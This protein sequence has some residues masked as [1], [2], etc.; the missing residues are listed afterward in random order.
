MTAGEGGRRIDAN[1]VAALS[2]LHTAER[3]ELT[4]LDIQLITIAGILSVYLG[5][6]FTAWLPNAG[7]LPW[8]I[9]L[10]LPYPP[11]LVWTVFLSRL[12]LARKIIA[13]L[14]TIS[15]ELTVIAGLPADSVGIPA[16]LPTD[17]SAATRFVQ[18]LTYLGL[19]AMSAIFTVLCMIALFMH[20]DP[21]VGALASVFYGPAYGF[22]GYRF[23]RFMFDKHG[24]SRLSF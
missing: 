3:N 19:G 22:V 20:G 7:K 18:F 9:F 16:H 4:S 5:A 21:H 17:R 12:I 2:S 8:E 14:L 11:L 6:V 23:L 1:S 24:V 10:A 13:S 15:K